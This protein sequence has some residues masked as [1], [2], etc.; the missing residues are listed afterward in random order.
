MIKPE[1]TDVVIK[2][3]D[4]GFYQNYSI[5]I[6]LGSKS[7]IIALALWALLW[8]E[9]TNNLLGSIKWSLLENFNAFYI[10]LFGLFSCFLIFIAVVP[11]IGKRVMGLPGDKPEFSTFSWFSMMFGA[12]LGVGLMVFSTAEPL[13]LWASNPAILAQ[14]VEANTVEALLP[15]YRYTFAHYGFHTW[16]VF[17]IVGLALAYCSYTRGMPLTLRSTLTPLIGKHANGVLGHIVDILGVVA[18][19]LA[20][21]TTIGFGVSQLIDGIYTITGIEWIMNISGDIPTPSNTGLIAGLALI[22]ILS[23]V[24]AVS[25]VGRGVKYLSNLNLILSIFLLLI[26]VFFGSF[27]FAMTTYGTAFIDYILH[28]ISLSFNAYLPMSESQYLELIPE[29]A[30]TFSSELFANSTNAWGSY[31]S[32]L[33]SLSDKAAA[34]DEDTLKQ[35]YMAGNEGRQFAWQAGWTTFYWAWM[36]AYAPFVG[37]FLARI[38]KGRTIREFILGCVI[39]PS[40]VCFAW[41]TVLGATAID[42]ELSGMANGAIIDASNTNK[43]FIT[44]GYI[45]EGEFLS[46]V[47]IM[48]VILVLTFLITSA[49][50]GILV[51]NTIMSGGDQDAGIK[52]RIV[53]GAILTAVIGTLLLAAGDN[54]PMEALRNAMIIGA[55]PFAMIL[56]LMMIAMCKAMYVDSLLL[57]Q[58]K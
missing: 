56:G 18:T 54:N 46:L 20:V 51:M 16:G 44:L 58:E 22:M 39:A 47:N 37:L 17:V 49:D 7:I 23:I 4:A 11:S 14:E 6:A 55:L 25:G 10:I 30:K 27:F 12:G 8:P 43:L 36:V 24:S 40:L 53:W 1:F 19:I 35:A 38:S 13:G 32:F 3:S 15:T 9:S 34:L 50:S 48:C 31:Q 28:Y 26:F 33:S 5:P 21:S 29:S 2:K 42:L 41:M 57:K 52:H 45:L